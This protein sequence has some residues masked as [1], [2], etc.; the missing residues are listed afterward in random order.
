MLKIGEK[1]EIIDLTR[2][3]IDGMYH[4]SGDPIPRIKTFST[5]EDKG[6]ALTEF[7]LGSHS[8]THVD[9]PSHK[10]STGTTIDKVPLEK[11]F[12]E[13]IVF[14][15]TH[16]KPSEAITA[17]DLEEASS[18]RVK[19]SDIVLI[20]TGM[21]VHWGKSKYLT[22][23]P[24]LTEDAAKWLVNSKVKLVGID[25][26][27]IE[28]FGSKKG[29]A[30]H[31]LLSKEIL[32]VENLINLDKIKDERVLF[33]CFPLKLAGRDGAPARAIAIKTKKG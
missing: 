24:Y 20:L 27:T 4:F 28:K 18:G 19:P 1:M 13:A 17:K 11:F 31:T 15:L 32:I 29:L 22:E 12:G 9:A 7:T 2:P 25:W 16:K 3:I 10:I 33:A 30:H 6:W 14:D 8:G 23:Y 26:L 5:I 21:A